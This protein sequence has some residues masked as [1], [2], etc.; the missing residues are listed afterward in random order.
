MTKTKLLIPT[1]VRNVSARQYLNEAKRNSVNNNIESV[2]FIPP[3][4]GSSDYGSFQI[5]YKTPV[6]VAR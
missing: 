2:R 4:I 3:T 6:L 1:K 5:T